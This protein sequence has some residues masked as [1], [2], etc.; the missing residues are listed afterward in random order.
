MDQQPAPQAP[1]P[2]PIQP[3]PPQPPMPPVQPLSPYPSANPSVAPQ[4]LQTTHSKVPFYR[5]YW[6]FAAIYLILPP[7]IGLV[8]LF[9][10][11]IYKKQK[12][13][14]QLPIK[15]REKLILTVLAFIFWGYALFHR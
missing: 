2:P 3:A 12:D 9:T 6:I 7:I 10:G 1:Q 11:N 5:S 15:S 14:Q 13:G 4:V 8:I